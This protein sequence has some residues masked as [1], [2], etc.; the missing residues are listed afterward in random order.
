MVETVTVL[1]PMGEV[2]VGPLTKPFDPQV[3]Y[4]NRAGLY[5]W[6]SVSWRILSDAQPTEKADAVPLRCY[7]LK[8]IALDPHIRSELPSNHVFDFSEFSWILALLIGHQLHGEAGPLLTN[9]YANIFYLRTG[10]GLFSV[11]AP[12]IDDRW[13]LRGWDLE[14]SGKWA[15]GHRVFSRN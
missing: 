13:E 2:I 9:G 10:P 8:K 12:W 4:K 14:G 3:F 11:S 15:A 1:A 6:D 7:D 5:V